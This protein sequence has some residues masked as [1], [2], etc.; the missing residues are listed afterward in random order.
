MND[1]ISPKGRVIV[2][3]DMEGKNSYSFQ[4]GTKIYLGR[5]F[6]NLN[7]RYTEPVNATVISS[8][9][10]P[11]GSECLI[12]HNCTH[13]V[14]RIFNY[15]SLNGGE[16]ASSIKYYSLKEY[17]VF[18][19]REPNTIQWIPNKGYATALRI[20]K[21]YNGS[22]AG[23]EPTQLK[24]ILWVTSGKYKDNAVKTVKAADYQIVLQ[25]SNGREHNIIRFRPDGL[26]DREVEAI[27]ILPEL[28]EKILNGDLLVG[29][30]VSDCKSLTEFV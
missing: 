13:D 17:E 25:E 2:S 27:C 22:V 14:N 5:K 10:I 6:N 21:P 4:D 8:E 19:Y 15:H 23:I 7:K 28:T 16:E 11:E 30:S 1:L 20:F 26:D 29:I 18:F 12:H 9:Y 24:D 3:V